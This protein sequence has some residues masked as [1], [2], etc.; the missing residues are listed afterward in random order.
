MQPGAGLFNL[1]PE[2]WNEQSGSSNNEE[3][4]SSGEQM[5]L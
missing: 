2:V 4:A 3:P 5:F 1:E